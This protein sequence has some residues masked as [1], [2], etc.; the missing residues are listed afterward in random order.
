MKKTLYFIILAIICILSLNVKA[1]TCSTNV[2][3]ELKD[4]AK[5]IEF[6]Y[7]VQWDKDKHKDTKKE[8][9]YP[10][11]YITAT[12]LNSRLKVLIEDNFINDNYVEFKGDKEGKATVGPF[13]AGDKVTITIR[14]FTSDECSTK[15][16]MTKSMKMPY[17]NLLSY[18]PVCSVY[19]DFEYCQEFVEEKISADKFNDEFKKYIEK[20]TPTDTNS[21]PTQNTKTESKTILSKTLLIIIPSIVGIMIIIFITLMIRQRRK[22]LI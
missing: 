10:R 11:F 16:I 9:L 8:Y 20:K 18:E 6:T 7:D 5:K 2:L 3:E 14:A 17:L 4:L 22:K 21:Q 19:T 1:A 15:V 12:N 13:Y